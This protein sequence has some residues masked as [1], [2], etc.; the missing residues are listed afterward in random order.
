MLHATK[1]STRVREGKKGRGPTRF[2]GIC[3]AAAALNVDRVTLYRMLTG[4]WNL[5][6]LRRRYESLKHRVEPATSRRPQ[7]KGTP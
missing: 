7:T 6:G 5:P 1:T 4:Q 2:P 3:R